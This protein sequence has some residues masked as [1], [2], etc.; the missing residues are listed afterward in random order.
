MSLYSTFR[1][2]TT[3]WLTWDTTIAQNYSVFTNRINQNY[4]HIGSGTMTFGFSDTRE[5]VTNDYFIPAFSPVA[6]DTGGGAA[7]RQFQQRHSQLSI[8]KLDE[9]LI[10]NAV[11]GT[12]LLS[13]DWESNSFTGNSWTVVN[14]T[15]NKWEVGTA[16]SNGGSYGVYG[17]D[18][19]GTTSGYQNVGDVSHFYIDLSFPAGETITLTFDWNCNMDDNGAG[20]TQYD[21]G[22]VVITDTGT[23]VSAGAEVSTTLATGGGNGRINEDGTNLGKYNSDYKQG[24]TYQNQWYTDTIDLSDYAGQTKRLVFTFKDDGAAPSDL[25]PVFAIDNINISYGG[26]AAGEVY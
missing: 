11:P 12:V 4:T 19:G 16:V 3:K 7:T 5:V 26:T 10:V 25:P 18:D 24:G 17:S 20:A 9:P 2:A 8:V 21:Y 1:G 14:D 6:R 22:A 23:T 13:E 15:T